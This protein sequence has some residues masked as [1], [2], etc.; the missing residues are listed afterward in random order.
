[1]LTAPRQLPPPSP[2]PPLLRGLRPCLS[3]PP[4]RTPGRDGC[5]M[6]P[7]EGVTRRPFINSSE[8]LA[9]SCD[10]WAE[11]DAM[12]AGVTTCPAASTKQLT[13]HPRCEGHRGKYCSLSCISRRLTEM[14]A[15]DSVAEPCLKPPRGP[16]SLEVICYP[17]DFEEAA[18]SCFPRHSEAL[19]RCE[20]VSRSPKPGMM[21]GDV[22]EGEEE[23]MAE[24]W[25]APPPPPLPQHSSSSPPPPF[26]ARLG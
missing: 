26:S 10:G 14:P 7:V 8:D 22:G 1:M 11:A 13:F 4:R 18:F 21:E 23:D 17:G 6:R 16:V 12:P 5:G 25:R 3:P 20:E 2:V 9:G 19:C 24:G 15:R